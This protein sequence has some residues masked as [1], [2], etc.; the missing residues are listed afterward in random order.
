[1]MRTRRARAKA[2]TEAKEAK[3]SAKTATTGD[4]S[5]TPAVKKPA[6]PKKR[7]RKQF[8]ENPSSASDR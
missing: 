7:S 3:E 2:A 1:M 8:D 4:E 6:Q 5:P